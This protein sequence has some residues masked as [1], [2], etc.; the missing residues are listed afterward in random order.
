MKPIL[1]SKENQSIC[2]P[3]VDSDGNTLD[4]LLTAKCDAQV[5]KRFFCKA[6][7]AVHT[8]EPRV[9]LIKMLPI[10]KPL[11]NLKTKKSCLRMWNCDRISI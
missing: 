2:T 10:P 11:L 9:M 5:A 3:A 4:F 6:L 7:S 1:K 8:Q